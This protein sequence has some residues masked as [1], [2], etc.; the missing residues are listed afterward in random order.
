MKIQVFAIMYRVYRTT[1]AVL[2]CCIE[3]MGLIRHLIHY[4]GNTTESQIGSSHVF[5]IFKAFVVFYMH[6][7]SS[8]VPSYIQ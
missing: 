2:L 5:L 8:V 6:Q 7:L 3:L 1:L 4:V